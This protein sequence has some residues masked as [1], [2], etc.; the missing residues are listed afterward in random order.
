MFRIRFVIAFL[1]LSSLLLVAQKQT[2]LMSLPEI[3]SAAQQNN[4]E[5]RAAS[6]RVALAQSGVPL[7]GAVDDPLLMYRNWGTPMARPYRFDEAQ[8]MFMFQQTLPGPGKR[9]LRFDVAGKEEELAKT[10]LEIVRREVAVR[11]LKA[12]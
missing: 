8:Q 11:G 4:P 12:F 2:A 5:I 6:R 9:A 3:E 10:V 7:A 1:F